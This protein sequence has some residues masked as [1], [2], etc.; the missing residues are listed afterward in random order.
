MK[1]L[2]LGAIPTVVDALKSSLGFWIGGFSSYFG[3][4]I[5]EVIEVGPFKVCGTPFYDL[6]ELPEL[7]LGY[8][9]DDAPPY[10]G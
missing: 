7:E 8:G 10:F 6:S 5:V 3:I 4:S 1:E 9:P 2:E